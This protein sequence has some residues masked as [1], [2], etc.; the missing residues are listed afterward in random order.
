[1][2]CPNCATNN[3][4]TN[5]FCRECGQK[6]EEFE[7]ISEQ[8]E[9]VEQAAAVRPLDDVTLGEELFSIMRLYEDGDLDTAAGRIDH[10]IERSPDS[11]SAHSIKALVC[12][13][14]ADLAAS[15]G[16]TQGSNAYLQQAVAEYET[17]IDLN[18]DSAA[19]RE[20]L[21]MLRMKLA[22]NIVSQPAYSAR[23]LPKSPSIFDN[24]RQQALKLPPPL[25]AAGL[26]FV[27]L[28]VF[29]TVMFSTGGT[30]PGS[31]GTS[32]AD[33]GLGQ[34]G[35]RVEGTSSAPIEQPGASAG[36]GMSAYTFPNPPAVPLRP[37][38]SAPPV[39]PPKNVGS[40]NQLPPFTPEL[41]LTPV[42]KENAAGRGTSSSPATG[43]PKIKITTTTTPDTDTSSNEPDADSVL[44]RATALKDQN[45]LSEAKQLAEQAL[46]MYQADLAA[47]RNTVGAQRGIDDA[48]RCISIV[49][50]MQ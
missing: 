15:H 45:R 17:I 41:V 38:E 9:A 39:A 3:G 31:N 34:R 25:L 16:D 49:E 35:V 48:K 37:V 2:K 21:V 18:P 26:A 42:P 14:K 23:I 44:R 10:V 47:G 30:K 36:G 11:A 43:T 20:K 50:S 33:S 24:L 27:V 1:M 13:R 6:L 22:G 19:D 28:V 7:E 40:A 12:E 32:S 46:Q 5:K 8:V 4:R 29:L